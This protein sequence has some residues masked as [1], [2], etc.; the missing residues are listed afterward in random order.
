MDEIMRA[1][2]MAYCRI[3]ELDSGEA[4]LL[5]EMYDDA[6]SQMEDAG[7]SVPPDGT[8][9]RCKYNQCTKAIVLD[10][11]DNRGSTSASPISD[12]PAFRKRIMQLKLTEPDLTSGSDASTEG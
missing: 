1:E 8:T 3:D 9:R 5:E 6:V 10:S 12:N 11:Y 7:V 4:T 2:L